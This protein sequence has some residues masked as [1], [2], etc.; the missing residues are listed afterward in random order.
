MSFVL[1]NKHEVVPDLAEEHLRDLDPVRAAG[2]GE[3]GLQLGAAPEDGHP[4]VDPLGRE[5][6]DTVWHVPVREAQPL[7]H[8]VDL[9]TMYFVRYFTHWYQNFFSAFN[10]YWISN[11]SV[12]T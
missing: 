2:G 11:D 6:Q 12:C 8:N 7:W 4:L 3:E 10:T 9:N 5:H 1:G